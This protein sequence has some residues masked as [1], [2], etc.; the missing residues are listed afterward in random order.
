MLSRIVKLQSLDISIVSSSYEVFSKAQA[1]R[2]IKQRQMFSKPAKGIGFSELLSALQASPVSL[3]MLK[4]SF[5]LILPILSQILRDIS[6]ILLMVFFEVILYNFFTKM[7]LHK[8]YFKIP[9][10]YL[11]HLMS[12]VFFEFL[13]FCFLIRT[14]G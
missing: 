9:R 8:H 10:L 2:K 5:S 6:E 13:R 12:S 4:I 1:L 14:L 3:S 11:S 7:L